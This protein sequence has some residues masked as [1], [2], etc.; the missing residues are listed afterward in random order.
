MKCVGT[1]NWVSGACKNIHG[2][3]FFM[4]ISSM[5]PAGTLYTLVC[6]RDCQLC[7]DQVDCRCLLRFHPPGPP[8]IH[9]HTGMCHLVYF[10]PINSSYHYSVSAVF[11]ASSDAYQQTAV[12]WSHGEACLATLLSHSMH[13]MHRTCPQRCQDGCCHLTI[14]HH[15]SKPRC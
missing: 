12:L 3:E 10:H 8:A 5:I 15:H 6:R 7:S 14:K 1:L 9:Q 2:F 13:I 11:Q 4:L